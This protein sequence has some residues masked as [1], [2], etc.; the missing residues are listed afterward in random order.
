MIDYEDEFDWA[1]RQAWAC[2]T[3]AMAT[4]SMGSTNDRKGKG[5]QR[6]G[7]GPGWTV[8]QPL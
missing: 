2:M 6:V 3:I 1:M 5:T 8:Q 7:H 4:R